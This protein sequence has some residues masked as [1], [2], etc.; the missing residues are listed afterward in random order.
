MK[1]FS[2]KQYNRNKNFLIM[3]YRKTK[4]FYSTKWKA[5]TI[6][7]TF[8]FQLVLHGALPQP[9]I[10]KLV[11][12]C[13]PE[14]YCIMEEDSQDTAK[15]QLIQQHIASLEKSITTLALLQKGI[16]TRLAGELDSTKLTGN[17]DSL[18]CEFKFCERSIDSSLQYLK[19]NLGAA[20]FSQI[21]DKQ[22]AK[23]PASVFL[24][25]YKAEWLDNKGLINEAVVEYK[26]I[27]KIAP[28]AAK[29]HLGLA[30][31]LASQNQLSEAA[32]AYKRLLSIDP[33]NKE[34][35]ASLIAVCQQGN[36]LN[37]LADEWLRI[38]KQ[39][40][41]RLLLKEYLIEV[42]HKANRFEE[43]KEIVTQ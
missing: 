30:K 35:Y 40:K 21:L 12:L 37:S 24:L 7:L 9:T 31:L 36:S 20:D 25:L 10:K 27:L 29:A 22:L 38:Y 32:V 41:N 1:V 16:K 2:K 5:L 4:L 42:L 19:A 43:A 3:K 34:G 14:A 17:N 33:D 18:D 23:Y 13:Q 11:F 8:L 26:K 15:K 6:V 39:N 28:R